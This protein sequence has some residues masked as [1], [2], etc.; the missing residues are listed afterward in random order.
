MLKSVAEIPALNVV[1]TA[2]W[3]CKKA[4]PLFVLS[5]VAIVPIS[6]LPPD[7]VLPPLNNVLPATEV[8]PVIAAVP[9]TVAFDVTVKVAVVI[10]PNVV[11]LLSTKRVP[12]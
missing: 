5:A 4:I 12:S 6:V 2:A 9:P 7:N 1:L 8:L 10:V 11:W 3:F